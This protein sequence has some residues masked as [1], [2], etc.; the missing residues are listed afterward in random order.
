MKRNTRSFDFDFINVVKSSDKEVF[1]IV[2][3]RLGTCYVYQKIFGL[4]KV[5]Y[6]PKSNLCF[7]GPCT[8]NNL[9]TKISSES[10]FHKFSILGKT[11][12]NLRMGS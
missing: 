5:K 10:F 8:K 12:L 9:K 11:E 1:G 4:D 3:A 2:D 7:V 6:D